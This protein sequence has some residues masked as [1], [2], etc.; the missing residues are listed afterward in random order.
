MNLLLDTHV[1]LWWVG[2]GQGLSAKAHHAI[3]NPENQC[4]LSIASCWEMAIKCGQGKLKLSKPVDRFVSGQLQQNQFRLLDLRLNHLEKLQ[5]LDWEH[6]DP[7]DRL[8]VSQ[9]GAE[10]MVLVTED[11]VIKQYGA[12]PVL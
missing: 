11:R 12:G 5:S 9:A 8:L 2:G 3:S 1:F 10:N 7:F 4:Y 6:R